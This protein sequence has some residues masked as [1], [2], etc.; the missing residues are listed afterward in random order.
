MRRTGGLMLKYRTLHEMFQATCRANAD[1]E[2]YRFKRDERW[3]GITW[4]ETRERVAE[5][6]RALVA[7]GAAKGDAIGVLSLT[8]IEW[9]VAD[10]GIVSTGCVT[11][12]IYPNNTAADC[13]Y[14]LNH[15]EVGI[16][17]LENDA[18][19][20]KILSV[21]D[22]LPALK[23]IVNIN[24]ETDS[25]IGVIGWREFLA[26]ATGCSEED[27]VAR[28]EALDAEDLAAVVYTSGT[29]GVP[30]GAM[31]THKNLV[32]SGYSAGDAIYHEPDFVCLLFLPL[33]HVFARMIIWAS[34]NNVTTTAVDGDIGA[35][36][37][38]LVEV[39]PHYVPCVPRV[40]EKTYDK[41]QAGVKEAG[42]IKA[43][44]FQWAIGVGRQVSCLRQERKPIPAW[45]ALR[46]KI[47]TALVFKKVQAIF[48]GRLVFAIS[49]S[50]PL[51]AEIAKF[52]DACGILILEGIG[53]TENTSFTNVNRID[54][55]RFGTVGPTGI[56]IEMKIAEDGEVLYRSPNVMKGYYKDEEATRLAIVDGWLYTG[57]IGQ[58]ED[59]FLKITDRKKDL[60]I[61]AGG[62]NIA[63]QYLERVLKSSQ[64][65]SQAAAFGD[66]R[67]YVTALITL[68]PEVVLPWARENGLGD[69]TIEQLAVD[70]HVKQLIEKEVERLN[71][72]LARYETI[73]RFWIVPADFTVEAGELTPT[74][75]LKRRVVVAKYQQQLDALY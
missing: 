14:I 65:I 41:I 63:P 74:M 23:T 27:W 39:R 40:F 58:I 52:F 70:S 4:A 60:I 3:T 28:A 49:G 6:A 21:R 16:L 10:L 53:M 67:R 34:M 22:Q 38:H 17:F 11:V 66:K 51:N 30:K 36:A 73:K 50:A 72:Q 48:G 8:S 69:K 20:E 19:L 57:D 5:F 31:I 32:F 26:Y 12:G 24:G 62:K 42:G 25:S 47:A 61:T 75:K 71:G 33:A 64:F 43:A 68:D 59:G 46:Y 55:N 54:N 45:L 9:I 15:A 1:I 18:Q 56:G 37:Q 7:C 29:T 2:A 44:L 35:V 13:K